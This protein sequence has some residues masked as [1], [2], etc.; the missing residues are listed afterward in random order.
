MPRLGSSLV[1]SMAQKMSIPVVGVTGTNGK[2]SVTYFVAS[3]PSPQHVPQG[4]MGT[5]GVGV[6]GDM[7]PSS[8]TTPDVEQVHRL[9]GEIGRKAGSI[10]M[11]VS[12][13]ALEQNRVAGVRFSGAV[14]TNL[15][16][17]H[18]D[19]HPSMEAYAQAKLK[20]LAIPFL[21]VVVVCG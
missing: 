19:Y 11:E 4:V 5:T 13:H 18:L 17:D 12:S 6:L 15:T 20:L 16:R 7:V 2:T 14:F 8:H 21:K 1:G 3:T 10:S 9:L